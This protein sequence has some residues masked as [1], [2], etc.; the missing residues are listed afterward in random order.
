MDETVKTF[1]YN[2]IK[3]NYREIGEGR[4]VIFLHGFG[5]SSR[6]WDD[7]AKRLTSKNKLFLIDLKGFGLSEKPL[8]DKYSAADQAEI[9]FD[10]ILKNKL[11]NLVLAVHSIGGTVALLTFLKFAE[12]KNNPIKRLILI[13]TSA[14]RQRIPDF[15]KFLRIPFLNKIVFAFPSTHS[16]TK[17]ALKKSFFDDKKI[18]DEI[19]NHYGNF[20]D[21]VGSFHSFTETAK[22]IVP[23]NADEISARY[24]EI[25]VPVL[26]IWGEKDEVISLSIGQRLQK[27]IP[28]TKL[29]VIPDCGHVPHEEKPNE[30]AKLIS[31]FLD[32][33]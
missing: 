15:I 13:G 20:L 10:F 32:K 11:E 25:D 21:D 5:A 14:Y 22:K 17:M 8:D 4:P 2:G 27:D 26:L 16:A 31:N 19:V 28:N 6:S 33:L 29:A 18:T 24:C 23:E 1:E 7:V 9:I 3:I 12:E 30:T